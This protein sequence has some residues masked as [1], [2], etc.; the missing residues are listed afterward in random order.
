MTRKFNQLVPNHVDF[1]HK[2]F[3]IEKN[4][5]YVKIP[6]HLV[7]HPDYMTSLLLVLQQEM[8]ELEA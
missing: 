3:S 4:V 2:L 8:R 7:A 5:S 1:I 6:N